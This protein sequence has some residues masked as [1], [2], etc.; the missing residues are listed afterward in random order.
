MAIEDRFLVRNFWMDS[1]MTAVTVADISASYRALAR[2]LDEALTD[3]RL[4]ALALT[5]LEASFNWAIRA[6]LEPS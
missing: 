1:S 3:S 2:K 6:V 5:E 4:K